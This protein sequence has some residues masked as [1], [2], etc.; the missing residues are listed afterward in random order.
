MAEGRLGLDTSSRR[1]RQLN[2]DRAGLRVVAPW[3]AIFF[4]S[5]LTIG[6]DT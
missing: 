1:A 5:R 6:A 3:R 2:L 4:W